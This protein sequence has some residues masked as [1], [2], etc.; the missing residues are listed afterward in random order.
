MKKITI[1]GDVMC[2][3]PVFS[4]AEKKDG[5]FDF[6]PAYKHLKPLLKGADYVM[7]NLETP[8]AGEELGYTKR[9]V[10][11]NAPDGL[12]ETMKAIGVDF[13]STANNHAMDRGNAGLENTIKALDAIG[14]DHTGTFV[15][16]RKDM[17][18]RIFYKQLGDTKIAVIAYTYGTNYGINGSE[19]DEKKGNHVN[20]LKPCTSKTG[21]GERNF[22]KEY[23][24]ALKLCEAVAGKKP[25]WEDEVKMRNVLGI[26]QAYADTCLVPA[27]YEGCLKQV[28][29]D[30]KEARKNADLVFIMPH[31]GGQF[32][33]VPGAFSE[34]MAWEFMKMGFDGV[35]AA[36]SHTLQKAEYIKKMPCFFSIGN[37]SMSPF[38]TYAERSTLPEYSVV[39]HFY[40]EKGKIKEVTFSVCKIVEE[41]KGGLTVTD[42]MYRERCR[43]MDGDTPV[44]RIT[45]YPVPELYEKLNGEQKEDLLSELQVI[46]KRVT[47]K[48][49]PGIREEYRL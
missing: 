37:V 6:M 24:E 34:Y 5:S 49:F 25:M 40:V 20:Y 31:M 13:V 7:A 38:S 19:P 39:P 27:E 8:L 26:S 46:Y 41:L 10:S 12:A 30:Y 36:H 1:L 21:V 9:L 44:G 2:E 32:N 17:P 22:T 14:L 28:E 15:N 29:A 23:K 43:T 45:V 48:K 42:E 47:G 3:P 4:Q 16:Y 18:E 11:F 33:V 35:L